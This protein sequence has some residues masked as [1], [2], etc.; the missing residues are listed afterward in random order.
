MWWFN[1]SKEKKQSVESRLDQL[2]HLLTAEREDRALVEARLEEASSELTI[3]REKQQKYDD[4]RNSPDPWVEVI[5]ESIDE[6]KGIVINLDW[7][8]AF[9]QYLKENGISAS[10][11]DVAVQKWLALMYQDLVDKFESRVVETASKKT[12]SDYL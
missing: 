3:L 8:D 5:G 7:N 10:D 9:I 2:E 12:V 4:K 1:K 6:I 11:E